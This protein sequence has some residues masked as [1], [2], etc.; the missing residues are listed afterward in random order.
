M[1]EIKYNEELKHTKLQNEQI[2]R[3]AADGIFGLD[4][5]GIITFINPAAERM[6]GYTSE[7]LLGKV[8][9]NIIHHKKKDGTKYPI[10]DCPIYKSIK[11]KTLFESTNEVFW[12]KDGSYIIVEFTSTPVIENN[13]T[14]GC[15]V[16]FRDITDKIYHEERLKNLNN[17]LED[18][19]KERTE[20]LQEA[21]KIAELEKQKLH[22]IFLDAPAHI[23]IT[24]GKDHT[25]TFANENFL[26]LYNRPVIGKTVREVLPEIDGQGF[27]ELLDNVY[28]TGESFRN[29]EALV[30]VDTNR[31]G[32][33]EEHYFDFIFKAVFDINKQVEGITIFA[34]DITDMV[35]SR[36]KIEEVAKALEISN[37]EL[38]N[39]AYVASHDLKAPIR[40]IASYSE[41][42]QRR[43]SSNLD[44]KA[45]DFLNLINAS[46]KRL[47]SLIDDLLEHSKIISD[48]GN[49][50]FVNLNQVMEEIIAYNK[51]YIND[52]K[53][54][55]LYKNLPQI[56]INHN[57]VFRLFN[58][59]IVNSIKYKS[60]LNPV[61]EIDCIKEDNQYIFSFKDNGIGINQK[62]S[63]KIFE[64]FQKLHKSDEYEGTG[65][66]LAN[67]KKIVELN[68][69][70]IWFESEEGKGTIFYFSLPV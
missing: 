56:K 60:S 10:S 57:H 31:N 51:R 64:I 1:D 69:G 36:K 65:I 23:A 25:F 24:K 14:K 28:N 39:F 18:M 21:Y 37:K 41:L 22:N 27:F 13:T 61:I 70:K 38:N 17:H 29:K 34:F 58:N 30:L 32:I 3:F 42:I 6:L 67:C 49:F 2:L 7:E 5:K 20:Q 50:N 4:I 16:I 54:I 26:K 46:C 11:E 48:T 12:R 62:Y 19:V 66:G 33:L 47:Q 15:V 8:Q 44:A 40:S 59:L 35:K 68:N 53:A 52:N 43:Y 9:H 45:N 55:I 63:H